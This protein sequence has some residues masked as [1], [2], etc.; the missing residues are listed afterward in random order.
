MSDTVTSVDKHGTHSVA[1]QDSVGRLHVLRPGNRGIRAVGV[2]AVEW[3]QPHWI[4]AGLAS[5]R[6]RRIYIGTS[7]SVKA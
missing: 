4:K 6:L 3:P 2:A 5:T 1:D 7:L